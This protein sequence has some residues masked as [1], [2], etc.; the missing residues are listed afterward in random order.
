MPRMGYSQTV[1]FAGPFV[2]LN[3]DGDPTCCCPE[4]VDVGKCSIPL[5]RDVF[6][7]ALNYRD[8]RYAE[9]QQYPNDTA[10]KAATRQT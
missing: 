5:A 9:I 3:A 2:W 1:C 7:G 8:V 4:R 6:G 10:A